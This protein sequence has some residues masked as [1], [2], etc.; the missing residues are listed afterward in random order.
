MV[1][2]AFYL[3]AR[4]GLMN[5]GG[6]QQATAETVRIY[7]MAGLAVVVGMFSS[8][9][10]AKMK[11]LAETLFSKASTAVSDAASAQPRPVV[12]GVNPLEIKQGSTNAKV[13]VTGNGFTE[14]SK[15]H[16]DGVARDTDWESATELKTTLAPTDSDTAGKELKI[17]VV[18]PEPGGGESE[19]ALSVRIVL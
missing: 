1:A 3:V 7:V 6:A 4:G 18:T 12:S 15:I 14:K 17:T 10:V 9:A 19:A 8:Q 16:I 11:E 13:T 5:A 2:V